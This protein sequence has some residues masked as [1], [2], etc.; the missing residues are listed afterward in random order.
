MNNV[1]VL[2]SGVDFKNFSVIKC[3]KAK[4]AE[5][6]AVEIDRVD[7]TSKFAKDQNM[8]KI[9]LEYKEEV[10]KQMNKVIANTGVAL[11]V[12]TVTVRTKES[13]LGNLIADT[14]REEIHTDV[15]LVNGGSLRSDSIYGP[16]PLTVKDL[17]AIVPFPSPCIP[18]RLTGAKLKE[19]LEASVSSWPVQ[20]GKFS[21]VS[22]IKFAFDPAK[23]PMARVQWVKVNGQPLDPNKHYTAA[24]NIFIA[25]GNDGFECL[26]NG[27][28]EL[29]GDEETG[30]SLSSLMRRHFDKVRVFN[31]VLA[32]RP[33]LPAVA[34]QWL[35]HTKNKYVQT[36]ERLLTVSPVVEGRIL[37]LADPEQKAA[38]EKQ[39]KKDKKDKKVGVDKAAVE[40]AVGDAMAKTAKL[41][42]GVHLGGAK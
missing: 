35:S 17:I 39:E 6:W 30:V 31:K 10:D 33:K 24:I 34:A 26:G 25:R 32:A 1:W 22:G 12:K 38:S 8:E 21:Q 11:D 18:I 5:S 7:V 42:A 27:G 40:K 2:T 41:F 29:L 37:N 13:N 19:A 3:K 15:A 20:Q 28:C 16:G 4:G 9:T 36:A 14:A 23:E